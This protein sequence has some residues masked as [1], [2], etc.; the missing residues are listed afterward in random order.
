LL[1]VEVEVLI[2]Q[3]LVALEVIEQEQD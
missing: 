2:V 1:E 3:V